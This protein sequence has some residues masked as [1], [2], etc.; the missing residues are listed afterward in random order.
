MRRDPIRAHARHAPAASCSTPRASFL[1]APPLA[2]ALRRPGRLEWEVPL[3]LPTCAER[4]Q[5][6]QACCSQMALA[7]DVDLAQVAGACNGYA[8]A[9]LLALA[10]EA[11]MQGVR[12]AAAA[13]A[14]PR[15]EA[16]RDAPPLSGGRAPAGEVGVCAADWRAALR[17]MGAAV[18]RQQAGAQGGA[19]ET[20]PW[21]EI[22]GLDAVKRRLRR[23][24]EWPLLHADAYQRLGI[25]PPKGVLLHGPP[26]APKTPLHR[27]TPRRDARCDARCPARGCPAPS[28]ALRTTHPVQRAEQ[29]T[30]RCTERSRTVPRT[31]PRTVSRTVWRGRLLEDLARA[32]RRGRGH[33]ELLLPERRDALLAVRG[34]GG[35]AAARVLRARPRDLARDPLHR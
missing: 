34:R 11:A 27:A 2:E 30:V 29:R 17:L 31:V 16:G 35:A 5:A 20:L 15:V 33:G 25:A 22:G 12:R 6:L 32:R 26:G 10:R 19:M 18:G 4:Q 28:D 7:P 1:C 13:S 8:A 24:V 9:D 21:A 3:A 23:A 14:D